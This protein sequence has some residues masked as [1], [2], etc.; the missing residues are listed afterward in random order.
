MRRRPPRSTLDR[1]SAASDVYKRQDYH[2]GI[3]VDPNPSI[4]ASVAQEIALRGVRPHDGVLTP[5]EPKLMV[6]PVP[7]SET[8]VGYQLVWQVR[9][10]TEEPLGVWITSVD[11]H[12]GEIVWRY[13]H[14]CFVNYA[15]TT[16]GPVSYTHLKP[17]KSGLE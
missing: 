4:P 13:N 1:S 12:S 7:V 8:S 2:R 9:V 17:P 10:R 3:S 15:G 5:D 11:A 14:V 6:L 16:S